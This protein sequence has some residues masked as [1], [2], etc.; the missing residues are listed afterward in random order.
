MGGGAEKEEQVWA[1]AKEAWAG[2]K[3][4]APPGAVRPSPSAGYAPLE[5][6]GVGCGLYVLAP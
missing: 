6:C 2:E 1:G 5:A 4:G 3:V